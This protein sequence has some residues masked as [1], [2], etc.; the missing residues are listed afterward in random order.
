MKNTIQNITLLI[1]EKKEQYLHE[2]F[3][4]IGIFGSYARGNANKYSD[5]DIA[6]KLDFDTFDKQFKGGFSK[7][8]C[9]EEIKDELQKLLHLKVDLISMNSDNVRF[10]KKIEKDMLYI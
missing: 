9:I 10:K 1:S 4:I 3:E 5:I 6:Y 7:M 2:G 8:L